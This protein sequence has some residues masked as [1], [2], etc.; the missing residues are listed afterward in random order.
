MIHAFTFELLQLDSAA[1]LYDTMMQLREL[2]RPRFTLDWLDIRN[3]DV[4]GNF[5]SEIQAVCAFLNIPWQNSL[6]RFSESARR[7]NIATPSAAQ[8]RSGLSGESI[9]RW[10][11]YEEQLA[12]VLPILEPW[13]EKFGYPAA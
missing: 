8:V 12:P 7:Q 4:I 3:E 13:A 1:R 6:K 11:R 5:E 9:G 2:A 10:R